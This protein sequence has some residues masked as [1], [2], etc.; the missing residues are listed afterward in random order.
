LFIPNIELH[1]A[2]LKKAHVLGSATSAIIQHKWEEGIDLADIG[3]FLQ[4]R[5]PEPYKDKPLRRGMLQAPLGTAPTN[6]SWSPT[7]LCECIFQNTE[8]TDNEKDLVRKLNNLGTSGD[9]TRLAPIE[10]HLIRGP[11]THAYFP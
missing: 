3:K 8:A 11:V 4:A 1:I 9:S 5:A 6:Q 2:R 10:K 7:D